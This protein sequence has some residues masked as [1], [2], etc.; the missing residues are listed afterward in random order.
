[1]NKV[2]ILANVVNSCLYL[3][4]IKVRSRFWSIAECDGH[5]QIDNHGCQIVRTAF[6][7]GTV[8]IVAKIILSAE[9]QVFHCG[10][11]L[12]CGVASAVLATKGQV[13]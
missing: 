7:K 8:V 13:G 2:S 10:L 6:A 3:R 12:I 11:G 1:M 9:R 4:A 5:T